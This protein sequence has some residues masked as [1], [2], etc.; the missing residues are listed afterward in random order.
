MNR[1]LKFAL[2]AVLTFSALPLFAQDNFPDV[3]D[4]HWAYEAVKQLKDAGCLVGYPDG[5]YR[6]NRPMSRYEF[7][8]AV[9]ACYKKM[10]SMHGDLENQ[11]KELEDMIKGGGDMAPLR[12]QLREMKAQLDGMKGWGKRI[13]DLEKLAKEFEK[14]LASMGVDVKK[15]REDLDSLE[16]RVAK[17][18]K[19]K[20]AV[21]IH[22]TVDFLVLSSHATDNRFGITPGNRILGVGAGSYA[23]NRVGMSRDLEVLHE[24][25]FKLSGTNEEGPQWE[26]TIVSGNML[27]SNGPSSPLGQMS[28][29][30]FGS[31][32]GANGGNAFGTGSS[33][34][35]INTAH[36]TF[37]SAMV[38]QGFKAKV[39]RMGHQVGSYLWKRTD[40]TTYYKNERWDNGDYYMDGA[41]LMFNFGPAN[42]HVFGGVNSGIQTVNG[43]EINPIPFGTG[44]IDRTL[45]AQLVF[46]IGEMGSVNLAYLWHDSDTRI[47]DANPLRVGAQPANR[48]NVFG[49]EVKLKFDNFSVNGAYSQSSLSE[50]TSNALDDDNTAFDVSIGYDAT[51]WGAKVGYREIENFFLAAGSWGRL[52]NQWNPTNIKGF[53]AMLHFKPAENFKI[54]GK[55][56]FME[57][58]ENTAGYRYVAYDKIN[59]F[60]VG[61]E[62]QFGDNWGMMA[63]YEDTRFDGN[64][65]VQ[66]DKMR[67]YTVGFNYGMGANTNLM[68][69][70]Q[71]SDVDFAAG[72]GNNPNPG[73]GRLFRGGLFGTQ[74]SVKF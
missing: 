30:T 35:Y 27:A 7:A 3:P 54:W 72:S 19:I 29:S 62:Y 5:L 8:A 37:D 13:E 47:A 58:K 34:F 17:L 33:D 25:A 61:A 6:G 16:S 63:S 50:N 28:S 74:L 9:A 51:N 39:G 26:A 15:L 66:D 40:S 24:A 71:F 20:P 2:G 48:L 56:Q 11:I 18:E 65:G 4:N 43:V 12:D 68:L 70:Y 60:M 49:G 31:K 22:G 55:G 46:P 42:L 73:F 23:G 32:F 36:V 21:D 10:M 41:M 14:E 52:G 64:P 44:L 59:S 57:P 67:W 38:G 45:G 69:T 53:G 1:T